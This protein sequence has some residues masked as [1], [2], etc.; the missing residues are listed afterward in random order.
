MIN[1]K[2]KELEKIR[3]SVWYW[4]RSL[5][6]SENLR[7]KLTQTEYEILSKNFVLFNGMNDFFDKMR[8]EKWS[9]EKLREELIKESHNARY[10]PRYFVHKQMAPKKIPHLDPLTDREEIKRIDGHET[11]SI[12]I[13]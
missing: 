11:V 9:K 3:D 7:T 13:S 10:W 4:P 8:E 2:R 6:K 1:G 5:L 12:R